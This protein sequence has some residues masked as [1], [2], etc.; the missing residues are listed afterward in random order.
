MT[1]L[2]LYSL[3]GLT[4]I[5]LMIGLWALSLT[6]RNSSIVDIFWG[7]GFVAAWLAF[8]L[9]PQGFLPHKMV[10]PSLVTIW[11]LRLSIHI[12]TRNWRKPEDFRYRTWREEAGD[13]WWWQNFFK[14][15]LAQ[16]LLM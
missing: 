5:A 4:L 12:L 1:S 15:F 9:T 10:L 3:I 11:G 7:A 14:V 6:L 2:P 16:G 8:A 13:A